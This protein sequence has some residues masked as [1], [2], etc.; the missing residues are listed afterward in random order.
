MFKKILPAVAMM[1]VLAISFAFRPASKP[2]SKAFIQ[3][4]LYFDPS[5]S[6]WSGID[7]SD[8]GDLCSGQSALCAVL[9]EDNG[10]NPNLVAHVKSA[11]VT[12]NLSAAGNTTLITVDGISVTIYERAQ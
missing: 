8:I 3:Q 4:A 5:T 11:A 7:E 12:A 1:F 10:S 2:Q 6:T 9:F